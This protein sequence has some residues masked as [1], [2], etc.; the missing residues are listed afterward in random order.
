MKNIILSTTEI[1]KVFKKLF[2]I[3][4]NL[5]EK[6]S[7]FGNELSSAEIKT[8]FLITLPRFFLE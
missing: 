2:M 1:Y 7:K 8:R 6:L 4:L 5:L 3:K